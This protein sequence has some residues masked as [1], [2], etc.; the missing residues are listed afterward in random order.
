MFLAFAFA[1]LFGCVARVFVLWFCV[2]V[3][4]CFFFSLVVVVV[5]VVVVCLCLFTVAWRLLG[6]CLRLLLI[7]PLS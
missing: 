1:C 4:F 6:S 7:P 3:L 5:V 2:C